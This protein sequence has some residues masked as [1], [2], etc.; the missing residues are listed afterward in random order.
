MTSLLE[1]RMFIDGRWQGGEGQS[2]P[3]INPSTAEVIA[4]VP[5]STRTQV[6]EAVE[7]AA[8]A[9]EAWSTVGVQERAALLRTI[10][11]AVSE[12]ADEF[13]ELIS[14]EMGAPISTAK[15]AQVDSAIEQFTTAAEQIEKLEL[16]EQ[17]GSNTVT[18]VG[19]GVVGCITPWNYPLAQ[20][21]GKVAY[22]LA[23]GCTVVVKP[24][25]GAPL[26]ALLLAEI[27]E[28]VGAPRGTCNVVLGGGE[29]VGGW[30]VQHPRLAVV[31][32]TGST[33]AGRAV[34][35]QASQ[36][37]TRVSLELGGKSASIV[38]D[39]TMLAV[40]AERTAQMIMFNSGQTCAAPS[41]LIV[42]RHLLDDAADLVRECMSS[43]TIGPAS[44]PQVTMGPLANANQQAR[45]DGLVTMSTQ[46]GAQRWVASTP[47][48]GPGYFYMPTL[49]LVE[50]QMAVAQEE[51]FGPVLSLIG[52]DGDEDAIRIANDSQYGLAGLVWTED[53]VR[54]AEAASRLDVGVVRI[55]GAP[56]PADV[57]F[58]GVKESGF[59]REQGPEGLHEFMHV[60]AY[61]VAP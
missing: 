6:G 25:E 43:A 3:V 45:V 53:Q 46:E 61:V 2:L 21:A 40:A 24:S 51:V 47:P 7:A 22:A 23:A 31:S 14:A 52:H 20:L 29:D 60:K 35:Q 18:R 49:M 13:S 54:A 59:G 39:R 55:N 33:R 19:S 42:P 41:R 16:R 9:F 27:I 15:A 37:L 44:D 57:P 12:R 30:L 56:I 50:P 5:S 36:Q 38:L 17:R 58:G 32:F 1:P 8:R 4:R 11:A 34:A 10:A 28:S 26:N 48:G